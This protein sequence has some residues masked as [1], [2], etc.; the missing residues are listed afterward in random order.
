MLRELPLTSKKTSPRRG[1]GAASD[2][3]MLPMV[4][5]NHRLC[6]VRDQL[7]AGRD[8]RHSNGGRAERSGEFT[9]LAC[10]GASA[11]GMM[12]LRLADWPAPWLPLRAPGDGPVLDGNTTTMQRVA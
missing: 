2:A 1:N 8:D 5:P 10:T 11:N 4:T 9:D 3:D 6:L 12:M 7:R